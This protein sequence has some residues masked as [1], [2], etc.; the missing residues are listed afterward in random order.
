MSKPNAT[1]ISF[2]K[3][4]KYYSEGRGVFPDDPEKYGRWLFK[5]EEI[6]AANG[7]HIPGLAGAS[8]DLIIVV[9]PDENHHG[10]A[11]WPRLIFPEDGND[12]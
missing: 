2:K 9:V 12:H 11:A 1:F 5:Q 4:G 7:G 8:T 3:S 10:K 6:A